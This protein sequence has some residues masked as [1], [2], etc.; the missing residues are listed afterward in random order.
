MLIRNGGFLTF[1]L[2]ELFCFYLIVQHNTQQRAIFSYSTGL[3]GGNLLEQRQKVSDYFGLA[4]RVDSLVAENTRLLELVSN[5]RVVQTPY[6]DT[7]HRVLFD[8]I[9]RI[10]SVRHRYIRPEYHFIAA[11][12]IGNS[13]ANR[14]NWLLL[15]KGSD[16]GV[17][18]HM[19]VVTTKGI[20][21][22][23]RH[24]TPRFCAVMSVLHSEMR[25]SAA[26]PKQGG[27]FGTIEWEG[28]DP[29]EVVLH[30][31][32]KYKS[33]RVG[34]PVESSGISLIFPQGIP[35]GQ[36]AETPTPDEAY[37]NFIKM[38]VRL[39]QDMSTVKHAYIVDN[40]FQSEL[41][42]LRQSIKE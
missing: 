1:I 17:R 12:V 26:L 18:P 34:E 40:L 19:G 6:R 23:V 9:S 16:D 11:G 20:V 4:T 3:I 28:D 32:P 36:V 35:I 38:R 25:L 30:Q 39:S 8:T 13:L 21:G 22:I 37:P 5:A 24:V 15:N 31:I 33:I 27:T 42:A 41:E 14:N 29:R 7:F 10:D 2:V